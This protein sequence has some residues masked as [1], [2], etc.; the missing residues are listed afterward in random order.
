MPAVM[1]D[2]HISTLLDFLI[3]LVLYDRYGI[4]HSQYDRNMLIYT[5]LNAI[6]SE[7]TS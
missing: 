2:R 4:V 1:C 7:K 5:E 3:L 6:I